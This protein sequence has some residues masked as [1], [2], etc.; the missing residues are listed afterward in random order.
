M[1]TLGPVTFLY[2]K[3]GYL[4]GAYKRNEGRYEVF[5]PGP[6][7]LLHEQD[8]EAVELVQRTIDP[9]K[10]GPLHFVTVKDGQLGGAYHK[11]SGRYQILPPGATYCLHSKEYE[12]PLL[13]QRTE[14]F[15][16]GP[17]YFL[18]VKNGFLAGAYLKKGGSFQML[19]PGHT[20]Q[21][22]EEDYEQPTMVKKDRHIVVC[23]PLTFLTVAKGKLSGAYRVADGHFVEFD[24][25]STEYVLHEKEY[26]GLVTINK[27]DYIE[28]QFGPDKVITIPDGSVG[29]FEKEGKIEI[30]PAGFYKVSSE[31]KILPSIPINTYTCMVRQLLFKSKDGI[32]MAVRLFLFVF[33]LPCHT[34]DV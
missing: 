20:Y 10:L 4:G 8:Y 6:P 2:V 21:L 27:Y 16:L 22:N 14:L 26:H 19:P 33:F 25:P 31:F 30:R 3:E 28:Q 1:I 5:Q 17:F 34:S 24:D 13:K 15:R 18:T 7:Y 12:V 23:G 11:E 32:A 29:V 9:F